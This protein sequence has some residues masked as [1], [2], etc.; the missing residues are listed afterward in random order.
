MAFKAFRSV[1]SVAVTTS[2]YCR[3]RDSIQCQ[4]SPPVHVKPVQSV[5]LSLPSLTWAVEVTREGQKIIEQELSPNLDAYR[6][7]IADEKTGVVT[8]IVVESIQDD[9]PCLEPTDGAPWTESTPLHTTLPHDTCILYKK[10]AAGLLQDDSL[11]A[12]IA[13]ELDAHRVEI[14]A[15]VSERHFKNKSAAFLQE[16]LQQSVDLIA[17]NA[18]YAPDA[19]D[20]LCWANT[21]YTRRPGRRHKQQQQQQQQQQPKNG[22]GVTDFGEHGQNTESGEWSDA[23]SSKASTQANGSKSSCEG[24]ASR[25][26]EKQVQPPSAVLAKQTL[27]TLM[28]RKAE[29]VSHYR[30]ALEMEQQ[31]RSLPLDAWRMLVVNYGIILALRRDYDAAVAV[32][33]YGL[34]CDPA[35]PKFAYNLAC[36]AAEQEASPQMYRHLET[37]LR[38]ASA[39]DVEA[40]DGSEAHNGEQHK[41]R[42]S[43]PNPLTDPSFKAYHEKEKFLAIAQ[44]YTVSLDADVV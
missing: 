28:G 31:H 5:A 17:F 43:L 38:A 33:E 20:H 10:A 37:A 22:S 35:Y 13:F 42:N 9:D 39:Y 15:C 34:A 3:L 11:Y 44:Q 41:A 30:Q 32:L 16:A 27:E 19:S 40:F 8:S 23:A 25:A 21:L 4:A 7:V 26:D 36:V 12:R 14:H 29:A 18:R 1:G 2:V 6:V 24:G